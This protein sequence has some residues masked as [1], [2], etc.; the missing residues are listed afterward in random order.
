MVREALAND[1]RVHEFLDRRLTGEWPNLWLDA[2]YL[3]VR[4]GGRIIAVA[5][6]IAVAVNTDGRRESEPSRRHRSEPDGE[7]PVRRPVR[8][9]IALALVP[10]QPEG[11][12]VERA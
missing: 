5:A 2:A 8:G 3:K 6:M 9:R 4:E 11:E 12:R 1:E 7:R 10:A